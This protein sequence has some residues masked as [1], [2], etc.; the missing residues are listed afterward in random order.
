MRES[1][2]WS[3]IRSFFI[4]L[5]VIG[6]LLT[7]VVLVILVVGASTGSSDNAPEINYDYTPEIIPNAEGVRKSLSNDAPVIL[8]L[9]LSGVLGMDT[10]SKKTVEQQLLESREQTFKNG[11][12][13][14]ILMHINS[15]GGTIVDADAIYR[16]IKTY[17]ERY[18]VP[19]YAFADGLCASGGMYIACAADKVY[20]SD[21][22]LI[23]SV[24]VI[25][26]TALNFSQLMEKVG[27]QSLTLYDGK[28]KD[29]LNPMRPWVKGEEDNI[30]ASI[31]FYYNMFVNI[32]TDNRPRL[33]RDKLIQEYGA[34]VYP[35]PLAKEY[36]YIDENGYSLERTIK[37]L[38]EHIGIKD[39]YYQVVEFKSSSWLTELFR[40]ENGLL[41]G[42]ITHQI[43]LPAEMHPKLQNQ[44]LYLYR[45]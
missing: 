35:A 25:L 41:K 26:S 18:K 5:F 40:T 11:R 36:G 28:G 24:G 39:D 30:M 4:S 22:T 2:F 38:A 12:V 34:N 14:A 45:K 8:K 17:K 29:A 37:E 10:L 3:S 16:A 44:Y 23:G 15:P 13:K 21:V 43:D 6:G 19:V 42:Q 32:V 9:N 31:E 27:V 33:S 1:I 20:A 7:G